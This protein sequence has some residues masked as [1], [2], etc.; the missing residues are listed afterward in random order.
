MQSCF[1][2]DD[3]ELHFQSVLNNQLTK[4]VLNFFAYCANAQFFCRISVFYINLPYHVFGNLNMLPNFL[5]I[6]FL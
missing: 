6:V 2:K 4:N 3:T 5:S 1:I